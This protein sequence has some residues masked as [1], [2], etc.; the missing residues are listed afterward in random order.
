MKKRIRLGIVKAVIAL[1][2][3]SGSLGARA[4]AYV[5]VYF[6]GLSPET[7]NI[8][9]GEV[10]WWYDGDYNGPYYI[11][12]EGTGIAFWTPGGVQFYSAGSY[13]YYDDWGDYGTVNVS[14]GV[15][16]SPPVVTIT[17]PPN[18]SVFTAPAT[19]AFE[20]D[21]S[22]PDPYPNELWDVEFWVG[23]VM[24]D[25]VYDPPYATTVANLAAGSYTL[26][27]IAWDYAYATAT[28][29]ISI[30]VVNPGPITLTTATLAG[31]NF[32]FNANGLV[33]GRSTVL[34]AST[35][36]ASASSWSPVSTNAVGGSTASFTNAV[37]AGQRYFRVVQMP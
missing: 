24:V 14:P 23:S 6:W 30:T 11:V 26:T 22:D 8:T 17:N 27:A 16:N 9:E 13:S 31:G 29:S 36:P 5:Y 35:N 7:V 25:D 19:F 15:P 33:P 21:A 1:L 10:V 20:V 28:N 3:L 2:A 4:D 18:N 12:I 32:R 34:Q 37:T